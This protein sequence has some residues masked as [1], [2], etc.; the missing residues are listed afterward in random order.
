MGNNGKVKLAVIGLGGRGR[1]LLKNLLAMEDVEIP[2]VCD[3]FEDRLQMGLEIVEGTGRPKAT[4][5]ADYRELLARD[6]VQGVIIATTWVTHAEI[7]IAAMRAGKYAGLEV[8]GAASLEE[9]WELVRT[10]EQTGKPAMLLENCCYGRNELAVLNIVKQGLLGELI[11][12]QCGYQHDLRHEVAL[13][14][15]NRHNR[16]RNYLNRNGELY[17]IH[18]LG[19]ISKI[20]N[21]NNGNRLVSLTSMSSKTRGIRQ[22]ATDKFGETSE[23]AKTEFAQGDIL[24]TMIKCAKGETIMLIHDTTL[25][26]PYSR[27]GRVQGTKGIWTEDNNS[28]H[29]EGR[30]PEHKWES[31]DSY[32]EQYEHPLWKQYIRDGVRGGHGGMDYLVLRAFVESVRDDTQTPIDVYDTAVWMAITVLSE[33]SVAL[34][35]APVAIPDFTKGKWISRAAGPKGKY[36]LET[37]DESLFV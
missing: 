35:S 15:Q 17:P 28:I 25:P 29:I 10:S 13:G 14:E 30:S 36:S 9:C 24:T 7:A 6:D 2:A 1:G 37:I 23:F 22:W 16:F 33:E 31:F 11:H 18:G 12:C 27:A 3:P 26:R 21:I 4:G 34:G 20:L 5:Y 32:R 8:G 19:P